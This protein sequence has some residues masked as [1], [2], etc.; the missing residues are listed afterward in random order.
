MERENQQIRE[1]LQKER[2]AFIKNLKTRDDQEKTRQQLKEELQKAL[3]TLQM[4]NQRIR[5]DADKS[6]R[7][8]YKNFPEF[9]KLLPRKGN[10]EQSR[11]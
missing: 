8:T 9:S 6:L 1:E 5:D 4:E 7:G 2:K 11:N 3:H 10:K